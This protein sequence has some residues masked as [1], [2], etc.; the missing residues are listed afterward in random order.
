[1]EVYLHLFYTMPARIE[2]IET[3]KFTMKIHSEKN[4]L[5]YMIKPDVTL[6]MSDLLEGKRKLTRVCPDTKFFVLA[7]GIKF[8]TLT[9]EARDLSAT[10]EY[11]DNTRAIAFFTTNVSIYL[12][13]QIYE[14][15]NKPPVPTRVFLYKAAAKKWLLRQMEKITDL[16]AR[17]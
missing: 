9:K 2:I 5:E 13:G 8:F 7:E 16:D 14:K 17:K 4:Y 3:D 11:A 1:M 10:K 15:I 6:D 12:L